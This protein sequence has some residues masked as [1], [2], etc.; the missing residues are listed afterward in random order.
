MAS[1]TWSL[2]SMTTW[3]S[4]RSWSRVRKQRFESD[5]SCAHALTVSVEDVA[6]QLGE[7]DVL[8]ALSDVALFEGIAVNV[9]YFD[10]YDIPDIYHFDFWMKDFT[11]FLGTIIYHEPH[12]DWRM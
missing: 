6:D 8:H 9:S 4:I 1:L 5:E 10:D 11:E 12:Y 3:T 2:R 7:Y